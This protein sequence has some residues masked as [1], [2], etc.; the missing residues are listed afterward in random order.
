MQG[1]LD[2]FVTPFGEH[3]LTQGSLQ[4]SWCAQGLC[5]ILAFAALMLVREFSVQ[6][7][8]VYLLLTVTS[9][10]TLSIKAQDRDVDVYL[11]NSGEYWHSQALGTALKMGSYV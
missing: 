9:L 6:H 3:T 7:P 10:M 2:S 5:F 11:I 1:D 8:L 4:G